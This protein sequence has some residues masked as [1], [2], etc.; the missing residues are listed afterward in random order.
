MNTDIIKSYLVELGFKVDNRQLSA[1]NEGLKKAASVAGDEVGKITKGF[2]VAGATITGVLASIAAG[3]I[4][5]MGH[6]AD[7]DLDMQVFA[8]RMYLGVDAARKMKTATDALGYSIEEIVWGPPELAERYRQL[9]HDQNRM[10]AALGGTDFEQQMRHLR[11][12]RFEFTRLSVE[13]KYFSMI[14]V[15]DLS[16]ALFG[17]DDALLEK[18]QK[19]NNWFMD[20]M[21]RIAETISVKIAPAF[22]GLGGA[23]G[24]L[25]ESLSKVDWA[26][27]LNSV[28]K[29]A[30]M[31]VKLLDYI[32]SHPSIARIL[33]FTAT[34][35]AA[36]SVIP[37]VGTVLGGGAGLAA[38][39]GYELPGLFM[40]G[41]KLK[42]QSLK[43]S[44][45]AKIA[46]QRISA[47]TGINP[48]WLYGQFVH[49]TG[50]FTNRG[51]TSLNNLAG[52]RLPGSTEYRKFATV[53]DFA[54]YYSS[55]MMSPRYR[56]AL[57]AKT[58][59]DF[60]GALKSGGY[61][62][63]SYQNYLRG[64][65]RGEALYRP[66]SAISVGNIYITQPNATPEQIHSAVVKA[67][68]QEADNQNRILLAQRQGVFA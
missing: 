53:Q 4:G 2:L 40:G 42:G 45:A 36:G 47:K 22:K 57:K 46:A 28:V 37:G 5:M 59:A 27:L 8:R 67:V 54:D 38:G 18:L 63:D 21:P 51:A 14:L 60:F 19:F 12:I 13:M 65:Q 49:E 1:F 62:E 58:D 55:L 23:L 56:A 9:I 50:D 34:G 17:S 26:S 64:A 32:V 43:I 39:L 16:K 10:L 66:T 24:H 3:T 44:E 20:N 15:K 61:Y 33:G 7:A 30:T 68:R 48:A 52:I 25:F 6:V 29:L 31:L 11:D 41:D 35:A